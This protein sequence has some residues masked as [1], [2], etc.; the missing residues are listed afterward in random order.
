MKSSRRDFV[1]ES[2]SFDLRLREHHRS[3]KNVDTQQQKQQHC[4]QRKGFGGGIIQ[5]NSIQNQFTVLS[6]QRDEFIRNRIDAEK[7]LEQIHKEQHQVKSEHNNMIESNRR[8]KEELGQKME[9]LT[10]LKD[11]EARLRKLTENEF[12][13]IQD[14]TQHLKTLNQKKKDMTKRFIAEM[15]PLNSEVAALVERRI[16]KKCERCITVRSVENILLPELDKA[17]LEMN[18]PRLLNQKKTITESIAFLNSETEQ[19]RRC[20]VRL[21]K[22]RQNSDE[23]ERSK[24]S[25]PSDLFY[26]PSLDE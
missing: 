14:C 17:L 4:R 10:M 5:S 3:Q 15:D 24:E 11:K 26:G 9:R 23:I 20:I 13:A 2:S 25:H 6:N 19:R 7:E 8:A 12:H 21:A 22:L 1:P 18:K 16:Q